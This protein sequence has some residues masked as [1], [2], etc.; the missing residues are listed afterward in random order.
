MNTDMKRGA[1]IVTG[2]NGYIGQNVVKTLLDLGVRV[3]AVDI[4]FNGL[5]ARAEQLKTNLFENNAEILSLVPEVD[6]CLHLAWR[7][8]FSHN[9]ET[10]LA[11][12]PGHFRFIESL[13]EAGL[14]QIAVLGSMHEIG[15]WE[16]VIDENTPTNP[17]TYYGIA[18]NA[19]RQ[20][21]G[22]LCSSRKVVYQWLRAFYITGDDSRNHSVFTKILEMER[23]NKEFFPV[24][25]G[26]NLYDFITIEELSRQI[27][28]AVLQREI[29]G[30]INVCTGKAVSLHDAI[31]FFISKHNLKIKPNFGAYPERP[32]DSPGIWGDNTKIMKIVSNSGL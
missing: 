28:L 12:L 13:I 9:A 8:G 4:N 1:I 11:D 21:L 7:N 22:V 2:A 24:T 29:A 30:T 17:T 31:E 20:S 18:K 16:G 3:I 15:Y 6:A 27:S 32:Y 25:S 14:E 23:D 19:L 5:D 10:H 26:K